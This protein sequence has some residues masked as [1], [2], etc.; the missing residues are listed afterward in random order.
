[1]ISAFHHKLNEIAETLTQ[2]AFHKLDAFALVG[3]AVGV[4]G[5]FRSG[6]AKAVKSSHRE[7]SLAADGIF[8][9][10]TLV[11]M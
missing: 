8:G 6:T 7:K 3:I 11:V 5:E 2:S 4:G 9:S 10:K 1:M